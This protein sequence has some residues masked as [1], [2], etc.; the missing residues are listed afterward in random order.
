MEASIVLILL[1]RQSWLGTPGLMEGR[2]GD[3]EGAA[4]SKRLPDGSER[5]GT[6][7]SRRLAAW[8][9]MQLEK[10]RFSYSEW[11]FCD[12]PSAYAKVMHFDN[13]ELLL[14]D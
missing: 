6:H 5:P 1:Y 2:V 13:C 14:N 10:E 3:A 7:T 9:I 4:I 11:H 12:S 8:G